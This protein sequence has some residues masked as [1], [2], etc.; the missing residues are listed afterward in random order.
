MHNRA[1][2]R[3]QMLFDSGHRFAGVGVLVAVFLGRR[4]ARR[5]VLAQTVDAIVVENNTV[6]NKDA[7]RIR[8]RV[9]D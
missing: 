2:I 1:A 4:D 9:T 6:I 8:N 5:Q 7:G 3:D